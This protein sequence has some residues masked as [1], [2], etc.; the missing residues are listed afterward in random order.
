MASVTHYTWPDGDTIATKPGAP[1]DLGY[2]DEIAVLGPIYVP[3]VYGKDLTA[4]ELGSSGKVVVTLD[5]LKSLE[6][7]KD[8]NSTAAIIRGAASN[9]LSLAPTDAAKTVT[10]GDLTLSRGGP[11][12]AAQVVRTAQAGGLLLDNAIQVTGAATLDSTLA[13]A[14]NAAFGGN[15]DVAAGKII[16]TE[17]IDARDSLLILNA[18]DVA[19]TGNLNI[20]GSLNAIDTTVV[21]IEDKQLTL[22]HSSNGLVDGL[23]TND[24]AGL[25]VFGLPQGVDPQATDPDDPRYEKSISWRYNVNGLSS[26]GSN[27]TTESFWEMK[28]GQFRL[29]NVKDANTSISYGWRINQD[30]ELE[31]VKF[32]SRSV[33]GGAPTVQFKRVARFGKAVVLDDAP[34]PDF[35]ING[36]F[37]L[38]GPSGA[39]L[40]RNAGTNVLTFSVTDEPVVWEQGRPVDG[41]GFAGILTTVD[42]TSYGMKNDAQTQT[43]VVPFDVNDADQSWRFEPAPNGKYIIVA[44]YFGGN[45]WVLGSHPDTGVVAVIDRTANPANVLAWTV[46][47]VQ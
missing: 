46:E 33:N 24:G 3:R 26:L 16:K 43:I 27:A 34:T 39:E 40:R 19:L 20:V 21:N 28:G 32:S 7:A 45:D 41:Q 9:A 10:L 11:A 36:S 23:L 8:A 1:F 12:D 5:D 29:T 18:A 22:A 47:A 2:S 30:D 4:L 15:V 37:R 35:V 31:L 25:R 14:G 17:Q 38:I 42:N 6:L 44:S 13:V